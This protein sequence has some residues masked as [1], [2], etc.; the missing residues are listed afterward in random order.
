MLCYRCFQVDLTASAI[1]V[2]DGA[3]WKGVLL[4]RIGGSWWIFAAAF[5]L[6]GHKRVGLKL[7]KYLLVGT[8]SELML[9]PMSGSPQLNWAPKANSVSFWEET[10]VRKRVARVRLAGGPH[11]PWPISAFLWQMWG[12][13]DSPLS[14]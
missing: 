7:T 12:F 1:F 3:K 8:E 14:E 9:L 5:F 10:Q 13:A 2:K 6:F 4:C 11:I